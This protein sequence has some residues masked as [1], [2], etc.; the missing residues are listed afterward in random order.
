MANKAK[1]I[2][3]IDDDS[4]DREILADAL[5]RAGEGVELLFAE[6]GHQ[7]F[8]F[9]AEQQKNNRPLPCLIILDLNMPLLDGKQIFEKLKDDVV[10]SKVPVLIFTSSEK[11][12][13]RAHFSDQSIPFFTK[14]FNVE[15]MTRVVNEMLTICG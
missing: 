11:T 14:P 10:L 12:Q 3:Y 7:A 4:D 1:I 8:D 2:L 13:D 15:N 5:E 6:N 9:L